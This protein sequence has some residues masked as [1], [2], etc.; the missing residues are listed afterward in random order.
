[1][2]V[3]AEHGHPLRDDRRERYGE[4]LAAIL[5][6]FLFQGIASPGRW[7]QVVITVLLAV[8]LVLAFRAAGA[9]PIVMRLVV[10][11]AAALV[12]LSVAASITDQVGGAPARI[13]NLLLVVFAPP[14]VIVGVV[15]SLRS[16]GRV[17]VEAVFGVLCVYILIGM[18]F[19]FTYGTLDRLG[20]SFFSQDVQA[21]VARC[22]YYSFTTLTTV[23]Y[24]DL[25]STT[26]LG[27]TLSVTEALI[28]QIYLVTIVAVIVSNLGRSR[29]G[30]AS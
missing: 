19:A 3:V 18:F 11:V 17:T 6:S 8:T 29:Q 30:P 27:H 15:R 24:G 14:A 25:T 2:A 7:E 21:T 12:A 28:G 23:G 1:M 10:G 9:K 26:N 16:R 20:P 13:A 5:L 4:L 22:L